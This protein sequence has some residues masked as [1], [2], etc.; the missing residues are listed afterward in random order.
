MG[1]EGGINVLYHIIK[2][3]GSKNIIETGVAY[4]WSSLAIL[5]A[6]KDNEGAFLI[7]NDMPYIKMNNDDY[8]GCVVPQELR[9]KWKLQRAADINGIPKAVS[10]FNAKVDLFH[11]DSDKSYTG[12]MW[13]MPIIWESL[14]EGG[15]FISDD[16]NDNIAFKVFSEG[17]SQKTNNF[18]NILENL[19]GYL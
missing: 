4:G 6:I 1:G 18:S 3:K 17:L 7:S 11:Y 15:M 5:L 12:R 2:S 9:P 16:I 14:N 8:V 19:L 10:H 13:S